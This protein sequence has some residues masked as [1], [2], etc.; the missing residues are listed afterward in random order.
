MGKPYG[1]CKNLDLDYYDES[2][3]YTMSRCLRQC[4]TKFIEKICHCKEPFMPG[5]MMLLYL[6][7]PIK[8]LSSIL[9]LVLNV[10]NTF[11]S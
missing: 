6:L 8:T 11:C 2:E 5:F 10:I 7:Y 9:I 3:T 4:E 1:D